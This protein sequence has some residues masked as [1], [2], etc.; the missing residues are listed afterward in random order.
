MKAGSKLAVSSSVQVSSFFPFDVP[1]RVE[2]IKTLGKSLIL[3]LITMTEIESDYRLTY[4][5]NQNC[6]TSNSLYSTVDMKYTINNLLPDLGNKWKQQS[7]C[8]SGVS[9]LIQKAFERISQNFNSIQSNTCLA[10]NMLKNAHH[11]FKM[12]SPIVHCS[13]NGERQTIFRFIKQEK[14]ENHPGTS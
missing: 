1:K 6:G 4:I 11:S 2:I 12:T 8:H 3:L 10:C 5:Q 14:T 9:L 13:N 7:C